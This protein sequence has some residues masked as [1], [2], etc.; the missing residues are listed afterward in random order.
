MEGNSLGS[1]ISFL[2]RKCYLD[3]KET[4]CIFVKSKKFEL[5]C[6]LFCTIF[7][8]AGWHLF[9]FFFPHSMELKTQV[10]LG[11]AIFSGSILSVC[12]VQSSVLQPVELVEVYKPYY[13]I[14]VDLIIT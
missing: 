1:F 5:S 10:S 14:N 13:F 11:A 3:M 7:L 4:F 6:L 9:F 2:L 12:F 8:M